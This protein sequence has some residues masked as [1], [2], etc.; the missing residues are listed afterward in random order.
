V[1]H[2]ARPSAEMLQHARAFAGMRAAEEK[3]FSQ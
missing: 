1:K 3:D 2:Y